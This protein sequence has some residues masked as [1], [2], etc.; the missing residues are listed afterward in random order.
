PILSYGP[1]EPPL[2]SGQRYAWRVRAVDPRSQVV[3]RNEGYSAVCS[4]VFGK[5]TPLVDGGGLT[6]GGG[7]GGLDTGKIGGTLIGNGIE[8]KTIKNLALTDLVAPGCIALKP[9]LDKSMG[10]T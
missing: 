6:G 9:K 1:A 7:T 3:F 4:F 8:V 5:E 10:G 2:R